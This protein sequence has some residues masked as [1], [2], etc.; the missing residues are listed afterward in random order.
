LLKG[1]LLFLTVPLVVLPLM[2]FNGM[3][4]NQV[5]RTNSFVSE[6]SLRRESFGA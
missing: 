2:F 4:C 1:F 5:V 3:M 6:P